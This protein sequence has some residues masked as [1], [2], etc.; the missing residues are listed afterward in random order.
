MWI[1][2]D[3]KS[4]DSPKAWW[5]RV[6]SRCLFG[7]PAKRL[8]IPWS[9][10]LRLYFLMM[11]T[12]DVRPAK[13]G[14]PRWRI[15]SSCFAQVTL[16]YLL[17][18]L[19][20]FCFHFE[21]QIQCR[22]KKVCFSRLCKLS[23]HDFGISFSLSIYIYMARNPDV[24]FPPRKVM[25]IFTEELNTSKI[26]T[27]KNWKVD[28]GAFWGEPSLL[29]G[30]PRLLGFPAD[31]GS[32]IWGT[33]LLPRLHIWALHNGP[34]TLIALCFSN[35]FFHF[36]VQST[37]NVT[38][39]WGVAYAKT[40]HCWDSSVHPARH[41][42]FMCMQHTLQGSCLDEGNMFRCQGQARNDVHD[43]QRRCLRD[44]KHPF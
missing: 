37:R 39:Q 16:P 15:E 43:V 20:S 36:P 32:A 23:Y 31:T 2:S 13:V 19:D 10:G 8:L 35:L 24:L 33:T 34:A 11:C 6:F 18:H 29:R 4:Q 21:W 3:S 44:M 26:E 17:Q 25:M 27:S 1:W 30:E 22:V 28:I 41:W 12:S 9:A 40:W 42:E 38:L 14:L 7:S 5:S